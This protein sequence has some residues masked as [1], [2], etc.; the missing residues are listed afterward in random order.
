MYIG[1]IVCQ[2]LHSVRSPVAKSKEGRIVQMQMVDFQYVLKFSFR[3]DVS[4]EFL[5]WCRLP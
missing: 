5:Q 2:F 1:G 4:Y 3:C